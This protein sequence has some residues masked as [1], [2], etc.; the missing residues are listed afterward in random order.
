MIVKRRRVS[1]RSLATIL[2]AAIL[3]PGQ[4]L[5][6]MPSAPSGKALSQDQSAKIPNEQLDSS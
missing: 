1:L 2:S 4:T 6:A 3:I 5:T